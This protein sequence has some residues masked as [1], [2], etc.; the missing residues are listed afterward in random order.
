MVI[1]KNNKNFKFIDINVLIK[2]F[3]QSIKCIKNL[4]IILLQKTIKD[5]YLKKI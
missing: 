2:F 3:F 1:L 5:K 4:N